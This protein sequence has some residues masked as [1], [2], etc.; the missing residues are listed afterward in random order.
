MKLRQRGEQGGR[1]RGARQ[2]VGS[3]DE[4]E[5]SL[6]GSRL[7][8]TTPAGRWTASKGSCAQLACRGRCQGPEARPLVPGGRSW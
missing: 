3:E 8:E 1:K 7:A 5:R 4:E 6:P 2:S